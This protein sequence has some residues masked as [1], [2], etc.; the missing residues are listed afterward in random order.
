V[1][2]SRNQI[3]MR[4]PAVRLV[5]TGVLGEVA[6]LQHY[7]HELLGHFG[8]ALIKD[9]LP[10]LGDEDLVKYLKKVISFPSVACAGCI[11]GKSKCEPKY[12]VMKDRSATGHTAG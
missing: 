8:W 12:V 9:A 2:N 4:L 11:E 3:K 1:K 10:F 5:D 6:K 7:L